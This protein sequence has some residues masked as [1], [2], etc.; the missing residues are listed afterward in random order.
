MK[1]RS[2]LYLGTKWHKSDLI[3]AGAN[4]RQ[5]TARAFTRDDIDSIDFAVCVKCAS[6]MYNMKHSLNATLT[7][8]LKGLL[9]LQWGN[10]LAGS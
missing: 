9:E 7:R 5:M 3:G 10:R 6:N 4:R 2:L 1:W 8:E